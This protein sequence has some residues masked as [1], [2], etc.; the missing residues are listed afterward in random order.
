MEDELWN[1]DMS[2]EIDVQER[3]KS[4][5]VEDLPKGEKAIGCKWIYKLKYNSDGTLELKEWIKPFKRMIKEL[6]KTMEKLKDKSNT[7][8]IANSKHQQT[9]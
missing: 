2:T 7:V 3:N 6:H 5:D 8:K 4:W 1:K 9:K